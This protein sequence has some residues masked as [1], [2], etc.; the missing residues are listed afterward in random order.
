MNMNYD[1]QVAVASG[2]VVPRWLVWISGKN[3][4]TGSTESAGFWTG[5]DNAEFTID[6]QV[7]DYTG[8]GPLISIDAIKYAAGTEIQMQSLEFSMFSDEVEAQIY[9]YDIRLAPVELHLA[10]FSPDTGELVGIATSFKGWIEDPD[11]VDSASG[12]R[13]LRLSVASEARAGTKT[14]AT[15]RSAQSMQ[16]RNPDEAGFDYADIS[17]DVSIAWGG[18]DKNGY[19]AGS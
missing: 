16:L 11:V 18:Q 4:Q 9:Q 10:L 15:K 5:D 13:S 19:F 6:G 8:A 12:G 17:G 7:R 2:V 1:M 14:L 3:R